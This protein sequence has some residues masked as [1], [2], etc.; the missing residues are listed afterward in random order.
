VIDVGRLTERI[1][2]PDSPDVVVG[3]RLKRADPRSGAGTP[4]SIACPTASSSASSSRH[5]LRLQALQARGARADQGRVRGAFFT[6]E[7]LIKLR[8][9]GRRIAE[10]GVPH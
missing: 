2:A 6:A 5:R 1:A 10:V 4:A 3:F 9:E 8:F 7:L